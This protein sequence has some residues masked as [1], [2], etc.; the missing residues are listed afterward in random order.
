MK[1]IVDNDVL[2]SEVCRHLAA[3]NK[4]KLRAKGDS[5]NPCIRGGSDIMVIAPANTLHKGNIVLA[6][7]NGDK[8]VVHRIIRIDG[9]H[10]V[11]R[12]DGNLSGHE[13]CDTPDVYGIVESVIRNGK[14]LSL[15]SF[16]CRALAIVWALSLPLRRILYKI[17]NR[18]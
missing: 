16:Q 10:I 2:L 3:G 4:V 7:V 5:M 13:S 11:L 12:G 9:C 15:T 18:L 17:R 1:R 6:K 14:M 8:F